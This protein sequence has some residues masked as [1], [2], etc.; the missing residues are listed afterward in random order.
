MAVAISPGNAG[1]TSVISYRVFLANEKHLSDFNFVLQ[2]LLQ[3]LLLHDNLSHHFWMNTAVVGVG[4]GLG[5]CVR[6]FV[7]GVEGPGLE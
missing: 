7:I 5:E 6:V 3:S 2:I 1:D 4:S